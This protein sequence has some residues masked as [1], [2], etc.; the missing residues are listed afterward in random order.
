MVGLSSA[1]VVSINASLHGTE[2]VLIQRRTTF[3]DRSRSR[4][5]CACCDQ[6]LL[7]S[8]TASRAISIRDGRRDAARVRR[9]A[10]K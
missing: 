6:C 10:E 9:M 8:V 4:A 2:K 3:R 1:P 5:G 7:Y